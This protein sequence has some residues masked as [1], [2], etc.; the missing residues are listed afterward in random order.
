MRLSSSRTR[1]VLLAAAAAG[2]AVPLLSALAPGAAHASGSARCDGGGFSTLGQSVAA[3]RFRGTVAAPSGRF[4]VQGKYTQFEIDPSDFAVFG[5]TLT[6]AANAA[7][8]TG[9]VPTQVY[10][11]QVPDLRGD[12]L[13]GDISLRLQD[14]KIVISRNAPDGS[15]VTLQANDCA[16][17]GLLQLEPQ[18]ADGTRTR[19]VNTLADGMFYFDN[20]NF[21]AQLGQFLGADCTDPQTGPPGD[22]CVQVTPKVNIAGDAAPGVVARDSPQV[23]TRIQQASCGPDFTNTL[24]LTETQNE[25]G[26]MN[27]WDVA[28]GGR[29]G[30]VFGGDATEVANP[31]AACTAD[32]QGMD[33][34]MGRLAVLGFPSPV[35]AA[36]RLTPRTSTDGVAAPLTAP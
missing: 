6:G 21:R 5:V 9:G 33:Q 17:G 27:I 23:A 20:P 12:T 2:L 35:P 10:A 34:V 24:G 7:D 25:C 28:S 22:F 11:S 19:V 8:L 4:L 29:I 3:G 14:Q 18:R 30:D 13:A 26:G 15:S 36:S 31:A 16:Q 32:C 1:H